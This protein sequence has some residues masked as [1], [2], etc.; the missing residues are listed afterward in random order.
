MGFHHLLVGED[1]HEPSNVQVRNISGVT[2][3]SLKVVK[4]SG[5]D[6]GLPTV[7][8][9]TAETDEPAGLINAEILNNSNGSITALGFV[10]GVNTATFSNLDLIFSDANG[11]LTIT[12]TGLKVG[13][14]LLSDITNGVIFVDPAGIAGDAGLVTAHDDVDSA[15]S[16]SIITDAERLGLH[17][18]DSDTKLD[19][20]QVNEVTSADL[21][22]H[23]DDGVPNVN[24]LTDLELTDVQAID[25]VF[26]GAEKTKLFNIE[27]NAKDDQNAAEVPFD[28]T[29]SGMAATNA[30]DGID[31][32]DG[33]I[34]SLE[35]STHTQNTDTSLDNGQPN[36]VT[37]ADL[38][39]HLDNTSEHFTEASID[40]TNIQNIG[41]NSHSQIDG[42]MSD[43]TI[44][45][46]EGSISHLNIQDIG[47][48]SHAQIDSHIADLDPHREIDDVT[49]S[50]TTLYSGTKIQT[51]LDNI[52]ADIG[53]RL[54]P[55]VQDITALK[56]IDTT[57]A[58][59][60]PDK[61]LI[62][63][64]DNGLY[65]L[66]RDATDTE[67]IDRIV[68]PTV[69]VGRWFKMTSSI[70]DHNNLSNIQGGTTGERNHLTDA[71]VINLDNQSG[72]NTG[73][74]IAANVPYDNTDSGLDAVFVKG[75]LDEL[76]NAGGATLGTTWRFSTTITDA[77]PG[78]KN[79]RLNNATQSAS[80]FMF[81][82]NI[83]E[84]GVDA[85]N[86]IAQL[87]NNDRLYIQESAESDN[88]HL[89]RVTGDPT[90]AT[91]YFKIPIVIEN[92]GV[93]LGNNRVCGVIIFF[94]RTVAEPLYDGVDTEANILASDPSS[95]P[96]QIWFASDTKNKFESIVPILGGNAWQNITLQYDA[97]TDAFCLPQTQDG[98]TQNLGRETFFLAFNNDVAVT[99][100]NPKVFRATGAKIGDED[101]H[102][103][104][105]ALASD[106]TIIEGGLW[107][108]N[109]T[110]LLNNA[111][112]KITTY[113]E[114]KDTNTS[115]W[116]INDV[117]YV[118]PVT[119]GDLTN[120]K[121]TINAFV[122]GK[123][124]KVSATEGI[125]FVNTVSSNQVGDTLVPVGVDR[126]WLTADEEITTTPETVFLAK[127]SDQG[128]ITSATVVVPV[129]D[130]STIGSDQDHLTE[131]LA[132]SLSASQ[133]EHT[134]QLEIT[135]NNSNAQ[136]RLHI[137][138]YDSDDQ[139]V[140][141]DSGILSEPVGDLGV[142]PVFTML[143]AELNMD[144]NDQFFIRLVGFLSQD[145]IFAVG[146]RVR[147]HVLCEKIGT[148]GGVKNFTLFFGSSRR[149][150]VDALSLITIND[151]VGLT[152][153][154]D[155]PKQ[156]V[157]AINID[158]TTNLNV[159]SA[160][161]DTDVPVFG[162]STTTINGL[163]TRLNDTQIQFDFTGDVEVSSTSDLIG[164]GVNRNIIQTRFQIN[165]ASLGPVGAAYVRNS[166]AANQGT[167]SI[168][169][170]LSV[171]IN[172]IL[173]L[174]A[175]R[176]PGLTDPAN[177]TMTTTSGTGTSGLTIKRIT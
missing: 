158:V 54:L 154:I 2:L 71:Q 123:V 108:I 110:S 26:T 163:F 69:G 64:E 34:D 118:D 104:V 85:S 80:T 42:H 155:I 94:T 127:R 103:V 84:S 75:A 149:S 73:D 67:D 133:G 82:S 59:D 74:Q 62:N 171:N 142:R 86:I 81:I 13:Q 141:I 172:D 92:S 41:T 151:V 136:E 119:T 46:T 157:R 68:Q 19:N 116:S 45:F 70:N 129:N 44:H 106:P 83:A 21:R 175:R 98:Q 32:N 111:K 145:F 169:D 20:G 77:D 25:Q 143:S 58:V 35:G 144:A 31:E 140:V 115:L 52:A 12:E 57:V 138:V 43:P 50:L 165:N 121:P 10:E 139:G 148:A 72:V 131:V 1:L 114:V 28:N 91:T 132:N 117:L 126:V 97:L 89:A 177:V 99:A 160:D 95:F 100:L 113:G 63:V 137:E 130:N 79:F 24:H 105:K 152:E 40:H 88:F 53:S 60:F 124:S 11:N 3:T 128:T 6:S 164:V 170:I 168:S 135:V 30:Q 18:Q 38:R 51:E 49:A 166:S 109:T 48:N 66:D 176:E 107:G 15:G 93:D 125:I 36:E 167:S 65:R 76:S 47:T 14:I 122:V 61:T 27:E 8:A 4:Y 159:A 173:T 120:I 39:A 33:R 146:N 9:I 156:F 16:G 17:A 161:F 96:N 150:F 55:P 23:L 78:N 90:D 5:F 147:Y 37:A 22:L 56:A 174:G 102:D 153:A 112:G 101:F 162:I 87:K 29:A 134:S 7:T